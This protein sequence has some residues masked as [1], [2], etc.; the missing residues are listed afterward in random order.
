MQGPE[1]DRAACVEQTV[2]DNGFTPLGW[3]HASDGDDVPDVAPG[4]PARTMMLVGNAGPAMWQRFSAERDPAKDTLDAWSRDVLCALAAEL[5]ACALF[6]FDKPPLPFQRWATRAGT[7]HTSPL[8]MSIHGEYGLWHAY[9]AAFAFAEEIPFAPASGAAS[10]CDACEDK[11]CLTTCP[12]G[13]FSGTGYDVPAC[14]AHIFGARRCRLRRSRLP[15]PTR[16]PG[17]PRPHLR[18]RPGAV[19]HDR[20]PARP[21]R[22]RVNLLTSMPP[23]RPGPSCGSRDVTVSVRSPSQM[24]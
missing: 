17:R 23:P 1:D 19:P 11:P 18:A 4:L 15:S 6:P 5:G 14:A 10:P 22:G 3:F 7:V 24:D 2:S 20:L 13:A 8:G 21:V 9:R 16:L 12:V